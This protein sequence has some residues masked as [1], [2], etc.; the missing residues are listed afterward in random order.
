MDN[1]DNLVVVGN[2]GSGKS[3]L[4]NTLLGSAVFPSGV[5]DDNRRLTKDHS[6]IEWDENELILT[7]TPGLAEA[8]TVEHNLSEIRRGLVRLPSL[9]LLFVVTMHNEIPHDIDVVTLTTVLQP[10]VNAGVDMTDRYGIVVNR[11]S[12]R[13]QRE[14]TK[15]KIK[16]SFFDKFMVAP[17]S[18]R[19]RRRHRSTSGGGP[20]VAASG[21][22]SGG[23]DDDGGSGRREFAESEERGSHDRDGGGRT[24]GMPG[25]DGEKFIP[26]TKHF[27]FLPKEKA[28]TGQEN[29]T[30]SETTG[31]SFWEFAIEQ[32]EGVTLSDDVR[33]ELHMTTDIFFSEVAR[34]EASGGGVGGGGT[35]AAPIMTGGRSRKRAGDGNRRRRDR[36]R[37]RSRPANDNRNGSNTNNN[38]DNEQIIPSYNG[39]REG[40]G[41]RDRTGGAEW[42]HYNQ[43]HQQKDHVPETD[44]R[45]PV[46]MDRHCRRP[47][48]WPSVGRKNRNNN[49]EQNNRNRSRSRSGERGRRFSTPGVARGRGNNNAQSSARRD[50]DRVADE[51][52]QQWGLRFPKIRFPWFGRWKRG[53]RGNDYYQG[54]RSGV[55]PM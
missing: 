22:G 1:Y 53:V 13:M 14:E 45:R 5:C 44:G 4:L 17:D 50:N 6:S 41:G 55:P 11:L 16:E 49:N 20:A 19:R 25:T 2:Q 34:L 33:R 43:S 9:K 8:S 18:V 40:R 52:R 31:D 26:K 15:M 51:G 38:D 35:D 48:R 10:F 36:R 27:H 28:C 46:S 30:L 12:K 29:V 47:N 37:S 24:E 7:D 21:G 32:F 23:G 39:G 42:N 54:E 3:T